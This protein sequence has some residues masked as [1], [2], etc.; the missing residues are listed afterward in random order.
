[1]AV[2]GGL[3]FR[4]ISLGYVRTCGTTLGLVAHCWGSDYDQ[5]AGDGSL[6]SVVSPAPVPG[7]LSFASVSGS[8]SHVC[9]L[10]TAGEAYCWGPNYVGTLGIDPALGPMDCPDYDWGGYYPCSL[11]PAGVNSGGIRFDA[12]SVSSGFTCGIARTGGAYCWGSNLDWQLGNGFDSRW[13]PAPVVGGIPFTLVSSGGQFACGIVTNGRAYCWGSNSEGALGIGA[14]TNIYKSNTPLAL[15]G[16]LTFRS[17]S[18]G[19]AHVCGVTTAGAIYC[20]GNNQ[21]GQLGIGIAGAIAV[22]PVKLS[23]Q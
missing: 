3:S 21:Y 1:V 9:G 7:G 16:G 6:T 19:S 8:D 4:N 18:A 17:V 22:A 12:L 15:A 5:A 10:T 11:T 14:T 23:G 20:W 13:N 2:T